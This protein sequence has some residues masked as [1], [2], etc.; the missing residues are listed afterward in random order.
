MDPL[1]PEPTDDLDAE[2]DSFLDERIGEFNFQVRIDN[3][4]RCH[5]QPVFVKWFGASRMR[6]HPGPAECDIQHVSRADFPQPFT[7]QVR[8]HE[9]SP[10]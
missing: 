5:A 8:R 2:L 10:H 9:S 6:R 7:T 3:R 1:I 4:P